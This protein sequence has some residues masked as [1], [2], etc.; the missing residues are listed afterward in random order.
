MAKTLVDIDGEALRM[1]M[2]ELGTST[3]V[4]TVNRALLEVAARREA[5]VDRL[6]ETAMLISERLTECD[7]RKLAWG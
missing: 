4:D 3:K 1:A 7:V 5:H 6:M 2:A